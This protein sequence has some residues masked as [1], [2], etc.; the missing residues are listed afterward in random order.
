MNQYIHFILGAAAGAALRNSVRGAEVIAMQ[1]WLSLGPLEPIDNPKKWD[2]NRNTYWNKYLGSSTPCN[3]GD[4]SKLIASSNKIERETRVVLWVGPSLNEQ[5]FFVWIVSA[6]QKISIE[7]R[8]VLFVPMSDFFPE[9]NNLGEVSP[10]NFLQT[11]KKA[12]ELYDAP[13]ILETWECICSNI[14]QW[15]LCASSVAL[16]YPLLAD[17]LKLMKRCFPSCLNGLDK[18]SIRLLQA[19]DVAGPRAVNTIGE[20]FSLYNDEPDRPSDVLLTAKIFHLSSK[21]LVY[22]LVSISGELPLRTLNVELTDVGKGILQ[23]GLNNVTL[24][25]IDEWV[26]G[27]HLL[28]PPGPVWSYDPDKDE[29]VL[30]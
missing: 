10:E 30:Q 21:N 7:L 14:P 17:R 5:L 8:N 28:S 6:L 24:N 15:N 23:Q 22:P 16:H 2:E 20:I 12:R 27:V 9:V 11:Q 26:S 25:G 3:I 1:D 4:F 18:W 19:I 13:L 29:L